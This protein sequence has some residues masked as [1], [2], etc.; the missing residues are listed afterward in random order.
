KLLL[1]RGANV[2]VQSRWYD[3][4]HKRFY[5]NNALRAAS[6]GGHEQVVKLLLEK[7]VDINVENGGYYGNAL[8]GAVGNGHED[9][10]KL[11]VNHGADINTQGKYYDAGQSEFYNVSALY[12]AAVEGHEQIAKLLLAQEGIKV[13][14]RGGF[15]DNTLQAAVFRGCRQ[16]A[17]LLLENGA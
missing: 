9:I 6:R 7:G 11:L 16:I 3:S 13:N 4:K 17:K 14:L 2:N 1:G 10:V 5:E 15:Y 12:I 8:Q